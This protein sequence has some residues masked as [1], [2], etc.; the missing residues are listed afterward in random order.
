MQSRDI[1]MMVKFLEDT[2]VKIEV[3]RIRR[4]TGDTGNKTD[5]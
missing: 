5:K 1:D 2:V 4:K 3:E